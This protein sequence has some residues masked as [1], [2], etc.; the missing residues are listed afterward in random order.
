M[1]IGLAISGVI[2]S[3]QNLAEEN[4]PSQLANELYCL[5]EI[6]P[7]LKSKFFKQGNT[8]IISLYNNGK[9]NSLLNSLAIIDGVH[10]QP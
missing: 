8:V 10:D 1:K 5:R 3:S 6:S 9:I 7:L 2:F 4:M